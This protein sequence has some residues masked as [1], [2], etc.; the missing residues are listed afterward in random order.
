MLSKDQAYL[1]AEAILSSEKLARQGR[2]VNPWSLYNHRELRTLEPKQRQELIQ[3][4]YKNVS[5]NPWYMFAMS[6]FLVVGLIFWFNRQLLPEISFPLYTCF[7]NLAFA[8]WQ[9]F[10]P[11]R[12]ALRLAKFVFRD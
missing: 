8:V 3:Q 11:R 6:V 4:A 9:I 1:E 10:L 12:E 5:R 7:G 2:F